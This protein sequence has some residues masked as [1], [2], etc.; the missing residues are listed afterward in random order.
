MSRP[1][2]Y[3]LSFVV[4]SALSGVDL[5]APPPKRRRSVTLLRNAGYYAMLGITQWSL[6]NGKGECSPWRND[7]PRGDIKT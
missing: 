4:S 7:V 1:G 3:D 5:L 2:A 6:S